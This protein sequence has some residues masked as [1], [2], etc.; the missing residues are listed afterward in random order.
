MQSGCWRCERMSA[1]YVALSL[2]CISSRAVART[3]TGGQEA[4]RQIY[5]AIHLNDAKTVQRLL[6]DGTSPNGSSR[7]LTFLQAAS[8][9]RRRW[10]CCDIA[11]GRSGSQRAN[12]IG[13][14]CVADG[15]RT[16][17]Y[18]DCAPAS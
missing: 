11:E 15:E 3:G 10:N 2:F 14:D 1:C 16:E 5:S 13:S 17:L 7:G 18:I 6:R 12:R 8:L 4:N 9:F